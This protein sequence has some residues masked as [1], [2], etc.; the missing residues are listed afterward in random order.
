M[1]TFGRNSNVVDNADV[2][3]LMPSSSS[4]MDKEN[5]L[6]RN[7]LS[8]ITSLHKSFKQKNRRNKSEY[9]DRM[10]NL[11]EYDTTKLVYTLAAIF[12]VLTSAVVI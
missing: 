4:L 11:L 8:Q 10:K 1:N 12:F 7:D 5:L 3:L 9:H 6:I 2:P